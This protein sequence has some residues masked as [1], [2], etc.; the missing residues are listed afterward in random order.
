MTR[1]E[2]KILLEK[3]AA[4]NCTPSE[5]KLVK[6]WL[7]HQ[8]ESEDSFWMDEEQALRTRDKIRSTLANHI[9]SSEKPKSLKK[10]YIGAAVV[11][12]FCMILLWVDRP[13]DENYEHLAVSKDIKEVVQPGVASATLTMSD[14]SVIHLTDSENRILSQDGQ[15]DIKVSNGELFYESKD[16]YQAHQVDSNMVSIPIGG[17]YR[18]TLPDGTKVWLNAASKLKYPVVFI[19]DTRTVELEGEAYFEVVSNKKQPFI[20]LSNDT[21]TKVTGTT[22]NITAY[23]EDNGVSTTLV[24][25]EVYVY[26]NNEELKLA[27]GEQSISLANRPLSKRKVDVEAVLGWKNGYFIFD[28]Q[29]IETVLRNISRWYNVD[30]YIQINKN[31]GQRIG[32]AFSKKRGLVELLQYLEKLKVLTFKKEGRR[33]NVMI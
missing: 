29:E 13:D 6:A 18:L 14:G 20:V 26:K 4:G 28:D 8:L 23:K 9:D 21:E 5:E 10:W 2:A 16:H 1:E 19:G 27:P 33:V 31:R 24:D 22:F 12:L 15:V 11:A 7:D 30:I 32:G 25:G 17:T 3:Y